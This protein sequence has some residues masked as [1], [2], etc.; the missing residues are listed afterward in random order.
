[1]KEFNEQEFNDTVE[2]LRQKAFKSG[3]ILPQHTAEALIR[4]VDYHCPPGDF[5]LAVLTND[6]GQAVAC[7]D[8]E[9]IIA[10]VDIYRVCYNYIPMN[11]WGT[12]S[13]VKNW[14]SRDNP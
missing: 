4:Y 5:L 6:L 14:L 3:W 1:M 7:A 8:E 12:W 9:N 13:N 2:N 11:C 10:I